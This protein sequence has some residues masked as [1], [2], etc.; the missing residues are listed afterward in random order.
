MVI[1][2]F[3]HDT[4]YKYKNNDVWFSRKEV[5]GFMEWHNHLIKKLGWM[6]LCR[7][8]QVKINAY[9]HSISKFL[10]AITTTHHEGKDTRDDLLIMKNRIDILSQHVAKDF[11]GTQ[12][13]TRQRII[14]GN[15]HDVT[16]HGIVDWHN[17]LIEK[18][19]WMVVCQSDVIEVI[20]Y[21]YNIDKFL[22]LTENKLFDNPDK[23][24]DLRIMRDHIMILSDHVDVDFPEKVIM[25][26]GK[27]KSNSKTKDHGLK[28]TMVS[29]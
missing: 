1:R 26:G 11:P 17:H 29:F 4:N 18:L 12:G 20:A 21:K 24:Q 19:G 25:K 2:Y 14:P 16:F 28:P 13:S 3:F 7:D 22:S 10:T 9:K 27:S 23:Q 6:L 5:G 15:T 8:D